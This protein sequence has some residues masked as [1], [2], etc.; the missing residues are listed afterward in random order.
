[1]VSLIR[2]TD[3]LGSG[4]D[5][6]ARRAYSHQLFI[7]TKN[8]WEEIR[9]SIEYVGWFRRISL[10]CLRRR[11]STTSTSSMA[12]TDSLRSEQARREEELER[13]IGIA[14]AKAPAVV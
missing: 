1:M 12:S 9:S 11:G 4:P 3:C 10:T 14:H 8:Q 5:E 7:H 6:E 2:F 13:G